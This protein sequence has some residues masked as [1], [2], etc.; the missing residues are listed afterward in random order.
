MKRRRL[1]LL[2]VAGVAGAGCSGR[3]RDA[4]PGPASPPAADG[5]RRGARP[6]R[7]LDAT[8]L[9]ALAEVR[10]PDREVQLV[11]RGDHDL[12]ATV[13]ASDGGR[14]TVTISACLGCL[15][16]D[17]AAWRAREPEL[18][19]LWAPRGA[20]AGD[21]LTIDAVPLAGATAIAV[22]ATRADGDA[23]HQLHQLHWNDGTTQIAVV[24]E[25]RGPVDAGA[26][27]CAATAEAALAAYLGALGVS[28]SGPTPRR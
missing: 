28:G 6:A 20:G 11:R 4:G 8:T 18:A 5:E 27:A 24:C 16:M 17:V 25:A 15:P 10:V 21:H 1:A 3:S 9:D 19:A 2:F 7:P 23:V 26:P 14:A 13:S 22:R 12:A